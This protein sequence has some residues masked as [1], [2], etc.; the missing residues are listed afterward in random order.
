MSTYERLK[1]E[2]VS[3]TN[4]LMK[5]VRSKA[6]RDVAKIKMNEKKNNFESN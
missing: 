2:T 4:G 3:N 5:K 6:R 1:L